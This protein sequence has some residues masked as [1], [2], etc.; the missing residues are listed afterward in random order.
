METKVLNN[1]FK[2]KLILNLS[3]LIL[4]SHKIERN[5][6]LKLNSFTHIN[7]EINR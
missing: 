1:S 7:N 6:H 3:K 2:L 5:T 4:S